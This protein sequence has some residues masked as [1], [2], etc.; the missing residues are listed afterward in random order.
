[1]VEESLWCFYYWWLCFRLFLFLV[2]GNHKTQKKRTK[3]V[4][5]SKKIIIIFAL[6]TLN[7]TKLLPNS[8][9]HVQMMKLFSQTLQRKK[10]EIVATRKKRKI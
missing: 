9:T 4:Q 10:N 1:M 3:G 5:N 6:G 8:F 7:T 2:F